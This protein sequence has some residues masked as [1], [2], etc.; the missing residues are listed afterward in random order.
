MDVPLVKD[1]CE[2]FL[3]SSWRKE[4]CKSNDYVIE[5]VTRSTASIN[6]HSPLS[7]PL[8]Y[9]F[10]PIFRK[11][12][13]PRSCLHY[14]TLSTLIN[15]TSVL[16]MALRLASDLRVG[17]GLLASSVSQELPARI[18]RRPRWLRVH[19]SL[20][21]L[22]YTRV[23]ER[24]KNAHIFILLRE[25]ERELEICSRG[26]DTVSDATHTRLDSRFQLA[27]SRRVRAV[28]QCFSR[29]VPGKPNAIRMSPWLE[30]RRSI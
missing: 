23:A 13:R 11:K 19:P 5:I 1:R 14:A 29:F 10:D 6:L 27:S 2:F 28:L 17:V 8:S 12:R 26:I 25:R 9:S 3:S 4:T 22:E 16:G 18:V 30:D 24:E 15:N 7:S 21:R 20:S